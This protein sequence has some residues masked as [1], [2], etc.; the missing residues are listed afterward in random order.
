MQVQTSSFISNLREVDS[1][2]KEQMHPIEL[3]QENTW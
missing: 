3:S 1:L 2:I